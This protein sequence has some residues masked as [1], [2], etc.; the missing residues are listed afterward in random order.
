MAITITDTP[1]ALTVKGQQLIYTATST[2]T[3]SVGFKYIVIV[4]NEAATQIGKFYIARNPEN[5][6][7]FNLR[8]VIDGLVKTDTVDSQQSDGIIHNLPHA[9]DQ[10]FTV[11]ATGCQKFTIEFG[12]VY[13]D[14]L[15]EAGVF[16]TETIYLTDGYLQVRDGYQNAMPAY[17]SESVT[18][19]GFLLNKEQEFHALSGLTGIVIETNN[20]EYG[21]VAFRWDSTGLFPS[22]ADKCRY[23][24]YDAGGIV[25][26][27]VEWVVTSAYGGELPSSTTAEDKLLYMGAFP[28][29][30]NDSNSQLTSVLR[31]ANVTDWLYY[32][33]ELFS[34]SASAVVSAPLIFVNTCLPKKNQQTRLAWTNSV[35]GWEYMSFDSRTK[36]SIK[37]RSKDYQKSIG[38]YGGT[39]YSFDQFS[40]QDTPYYVDAD[41]TYALQKMGAT[42]I[43]S[44]LSQY[45][46]KSKNVM[47]TFDNGEWLPVVVQS[48]SVQMQQ[49]KISKRID[50]SIN[51]K[52]AQREEC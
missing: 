49:S 17:D 25:I 31:P 26:A 47:I 34:T 19:I 7:I 4:K 21:S 11:A 36:H 32:T 37:A 9:A 42:D 12:E 3:G 20:A 51:V 48:G 27:A 33:L 15:T 2:Q 16:Q 23:A 35:G 5:I 46:V 52:L 6:L 41:L 14:P 40:R 50:F 44:R 30:L 39:T 22:D 45:I 28:A 8:G 38:D 18:D 10:Q 1:N 24:I 29:N 43:E 13:G